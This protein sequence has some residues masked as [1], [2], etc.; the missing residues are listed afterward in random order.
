MSSTDMTDVGWRRWHHAYRAILGDGLWVASGQIATGVLSIV[1]TR[2][3]TQIVSPELYG[4][5]NLVQ[6]AL[7]FVRSLFCTPLFGAAVRYFPES[8]RGGY[9]PALRRVL[10]RFLGLSIVGVV[11]LAVIGGLIWSSRS[12]IP[13]TVIF[14]LIV[15]VVADVGRTLEFT[16][17]NSARRQRP[18]A[19]LSILEALARPLLIIGAVLLFGPTVQAVLG[20]IALSIIV[21]LTGAYATGRPYLSGRQESIPSGLVAEMCQYAIPLIPLALLNWTISVSDRYI[22][23]WVSH[24][25]AKVGVYAAGYGLISQPFILIQAII[26]LTLR[27]VYFSAVTQDEHE[28]AKR[29][30][31]VWLGIS[32]GACTLAASFIVLTREFLVSL[33]LGPQYRGAVVVVPWIALGYVIYVF[34]QVL[35]QKLLAHKRTSEVLVAQIC[36]A[37]AS[38]V[39]TI[40]LVEQFGMIGAAYACPVYFL[41]QCAVAAKFLRS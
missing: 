13:S 24:D 36:G 4:T 16:L 27:P 2:L 19:I 6:N 8:E 38:V 25:T 3:V 12:G 23:G 30:F 11:S 7:L 18:L 34:D 1:G 21:P 5:V 22:I 28:R 26:T 41:A 32:L 29:I 20:A 9:S 14:I 35:E 40:P 31:H 17:F 10:N 33:L 37:V 15:L 39:V